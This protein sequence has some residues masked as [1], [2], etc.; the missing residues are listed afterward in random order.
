MLKATE[1]AQ[2]PLLVEKGKLY[3]IQMPQKISPD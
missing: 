2:P 1:D 3:Y